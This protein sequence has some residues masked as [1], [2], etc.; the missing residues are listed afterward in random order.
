MNEPAGKPGQPGED[1]LAVVLERLEPSLSKALDIIAHEHRS[2]SRWALIKRTAIAVFAL[3]VFFVWIFFYGKVLGFHPEPLKPTVAV[4]DIDGAI[5]GAHQASAHNL[6]PEIDRLCGEHEVKA[7]IVHINSPGGSP[8]DAERIGAALQRCRKMPGSHSRNQ[9][10]QTR[11]VIAVID[12]LGASAAYLIA[13]HAQKIYASPESMVGSIGIIIEGFKFN[14]LLSKAGVDNYTYASGPIKAALSPWQP[15][16]PAQKA[17]IATLDH[18]AFEVF[19]ASVIRHRPHLVLSTPGLW[20]GRVWMAGQAQRIGLIDGV[21]ILENIE[22]EQF[23]KLQV[24]T[25]QPQINVRNLLSMSTWIHTL[26]AEA[27]DH[28]VALR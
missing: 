15:D 19:K 18:Q 24:H 11:P 21:G 16:T 25:Y 1:R 8:T 2:A 28:A 13:I 5:G 10:P 14:K 22:Q 7:L 26:R 17:F 27:Q 9:K 4:V 3:L 23:P 12:G 6:V 20:S